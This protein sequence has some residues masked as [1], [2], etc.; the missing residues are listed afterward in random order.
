[1]FYMFIT[2]KKSRCCAHAS[3]TKKKNQ[4]ETNADVKILSK[5]QCRLQNLMNIRKEL[6]PLFSCDKAVATI[7]ES[8]DI[9][10]YFKLQFFFTVV[11]A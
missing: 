9:K 3:R 4:L 2:L 5:S 1:M 6:K 8:N 10:Y 7:L 11:K